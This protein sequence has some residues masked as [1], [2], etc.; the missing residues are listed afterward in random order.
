M[1]LELIERWIGPIV[2]IQQS[3]ES[4]IK[5]ALEVQEWTSM[6]TVFASIVDEVTTIAE[7]PNVLH[8]CI[9]L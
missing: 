5:E 9:C 8:H 7:A 2:Q 6:T 4:S 3:L 1:A